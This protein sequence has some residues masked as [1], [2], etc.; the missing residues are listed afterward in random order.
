[1]G[2]ERSRDRKR[3]IFRR[4]RAVGLSVGAFSGREREVGGALGLAGACRLGTSGVRMAER[5]N[6]TDRCRMG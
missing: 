6:D 3:T 5:G 2:Q 4:G 1:M